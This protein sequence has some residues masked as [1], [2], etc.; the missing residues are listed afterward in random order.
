MK[1]VH[2]DKVNIRYELNLLHDII[3]PPKRTKVLNRNYSSIL[4]GCFNTRK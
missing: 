2:D 3:N 1:R 4:H